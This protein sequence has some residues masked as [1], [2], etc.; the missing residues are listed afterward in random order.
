MVRSLYIAAAVLLAIGSPHAQTLRGASARGKKIAEMNCQK[1]HAIDRVSASANPK[2]PP[3]RTLSQ[4]YPLDQLEEALNEGIMVGHDGPEM[5]FFR[6]RPPQIA[7][8]LA[9]LRTIQ[10]RA[11]K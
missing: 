11:G 5:P 9:Y 1:C 6:L 7:D 8:L 3:F 10:S 2:S 4:R